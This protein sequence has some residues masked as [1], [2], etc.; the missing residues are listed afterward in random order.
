MDLCVSLWEF[1]HSL[2]YVNSTGSGFTFAEAC[3]PTGAGDGVCMC[4]RKTMLIHAAVCRHLDM[5]ESHICLQSS[6]GIVS[7]GG[8]ITD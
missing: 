8:G 7:R 1:V 6:R 3:L 4:Y 5:L 2:H